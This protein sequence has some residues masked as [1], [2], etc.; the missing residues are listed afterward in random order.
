MYEE[1]QGLLQARF[2]AILVPAGSIWCGVFVDYFLVCGPLTQRFMLNSGEGWELEGFKH[3]EKFWQHCELLGYLVLCQILIWR[4]YQFLFQ[5]VLLFFFSLSLSLFLLFLKFTCLSVVVVPQS[6]ETLIS[7][8]SHCSL[9]CSGSE[10]SSDPFSSSES[11]SS[12][13]HSHLTS[14]S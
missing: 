13:M 2:V 11:L 4:N 14:P 1:T 8:V 5:I 6:L 7:F 12:P 3:W 9:C 10:D